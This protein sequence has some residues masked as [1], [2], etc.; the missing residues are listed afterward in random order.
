M[1]IIFLD[2]DGVL[3]SEVWN[4]NHVNEIESGFLIDEEKLKLL[5]R[6]AKEINAKIVLHSGWR[7][8]FDENFFPIRK[9]SEFL[10]NLLD[11]NGISFYDF[12]PDLTNEEIRKTGKFSLTKPNEI[13]LWLETHSDIVKW[14]VMDDIILD[15]EIIQRHQVIPDA[16]IGLTSEDIENAKKILD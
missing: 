7:F 14:V 1:K 6:L 13:L 15:N 5:S 16:K 4:Q 11:E 10:K 12:T 3:N 9:E 2:V 8:W